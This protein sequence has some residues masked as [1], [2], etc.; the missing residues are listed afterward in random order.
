MRLTEMTIADDLRQTKPYVKTTVTDE[1]RRLIDAAIDEGRVTIIPAGVC[2]F[3][4][5]EMSW[6]KRMFNYGRERG[7]L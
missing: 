7:T 4:E 6:G 3:D 1:E 5:S 2:A